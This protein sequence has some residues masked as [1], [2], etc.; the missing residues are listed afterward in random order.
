MGVGQDPVVRRLVA[1]GVP[2]EVEGESEAV[3]RMAGV[4]VLNG[5]VGNLD[6]L[7]V[8]AVGVGE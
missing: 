2:V 8:G 3:V 6:L 1:R 4:C 5:G 7:L